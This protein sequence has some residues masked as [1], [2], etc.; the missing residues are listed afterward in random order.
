MLVKELIE[1][2][3]KCPLFYTVVL[4]VPI[5]DEV[6][7]LVDLYPE[8]FEVDASRGTLEIDGAI[9]GGANDQIQDILESGIVLGEDEVLVLSRAHE[10]DMSKHKMTTKE[11]MKHLGMTVL[12]NELLINI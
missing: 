8:D 2:L 11:R 4:T 7:L 1:L 12:T 10:G 5:N 3:Q 6:P 9:P